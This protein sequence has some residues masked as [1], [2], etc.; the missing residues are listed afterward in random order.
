MAISGFGMRRPTSWLGFLLH[1]S[2]L[3]KESYSMHARAFWLRWAK[4][5]RSFFGTQTSMA[6]SARLAASPIE[7]SHRRN[8]APTL[9]AVPTGKLVRIVEGFSCLIRLDL[10][11]PDL[12]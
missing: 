10:A 11:T 12:G 7:T 4:T 3:S 1:N 6:G 2:K 9:E 5:T 8:G